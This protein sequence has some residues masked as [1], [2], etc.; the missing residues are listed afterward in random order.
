MFYGLEGRYPDSLEE[1]ASVDPRLPDLVCPSCSLAY[2]WDTDGFEGYL[3]GCPLP[4]DPDHGY[5]KDGVPYWPPDPSAW[6]GICHGNMTTL[7]AGLAQYFGMYNLYPAELEGLVAEGIL[8]ELPVCPECGGYYLYK[9]DCQTTYTVECPLPSDPNHGW[10]T[11]GECSWPPD[12]SG[13]TEACRSNMCCLATAMAMY[14]GKENRYPEELRDLGASGIM[15]NWYIPCPAC[16]RIYNYWTD[17]EG[18]TYAIY[19]PLPWDPGHG[20]VYDGM[21]QLSPFPLYGIFPKDHV[22]PLQDSRTEVSNAAI[23]LFRPC[24]HHRGTHRSADCPRARVG[25]HRAGPVVP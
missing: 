22:Y 21:I 12:T 24:R 9:T 4:E 23:P 3:L 14:Y 8:D 2:E 17:A 1:L 5:V 15:E 25:G 13:C 19:C 18:Q 7:A 16:G 6:P 11:D 10:I 20:S